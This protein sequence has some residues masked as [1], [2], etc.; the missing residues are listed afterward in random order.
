[1]DL[2]IQFMKLSNLGMREG[3]NDLSKW[4]TELIDPSL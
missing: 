3:S 1:M 2:Q 4:L